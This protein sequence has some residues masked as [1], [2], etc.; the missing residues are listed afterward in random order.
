MR[1]FRNEVYGKHADGLVRTHAI[2][3][4]S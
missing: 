1:N 3:D 4:N 2:V